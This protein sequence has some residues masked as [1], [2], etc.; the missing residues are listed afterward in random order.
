[1]KTVGG[2][3]HGERRSE[4]HSHAHAGSVKVSRLT[5]IQGV[6]ASGSG[7]IVSRWLVGEVT[8]C[9][10][11]WIEERGRESPWFV[12]RPWGRVEIFELVMAEAVMPVFKRQHCVA[13]C[14]WK[15]PVSPDCHRGEKLLCPV[16]RMSAHD[17]HTVLVVVRPQWLPP[18]WCSPSWTW[19]ET[20]RSLPLGRSGGNWR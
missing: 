2:S 10:R 15:S 18:G 20:S 9:E 17:S 8:E 3:W 7:S 19:P 4:A 11:V 14:I 1:M 5:V 12:L 6:C 13:R 16:L